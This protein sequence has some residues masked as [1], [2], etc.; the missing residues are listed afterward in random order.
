MAGACWPGPVSACFNTGPWDQ[1]QRVD[2]FC[3]TESIGTPGG[4]VCTM[5]QAE[6]IMTIYSAKGEAAARAAVVQMGAG[7]QVLAIAGAS[8]GCG[9]EPTG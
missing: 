7:Q 9:D 4:D 3:V 8:K 2:E 1:P 5:T 6:T